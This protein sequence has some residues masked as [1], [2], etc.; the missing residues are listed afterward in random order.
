MP[1]KRL[2]ERV[3]LRPADLEPSRDDFEV[4]GVFNP[5]A[6]R[7]KDEVMLL[8]RVAERPREEPRVHRPASLE[9][10]RQPR[11]GLGL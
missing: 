8:V 4:V 7:V 3:L 1:L 5:G 10:R 11:G 9:Q 2:F 6:V